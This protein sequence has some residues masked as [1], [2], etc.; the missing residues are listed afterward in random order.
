M[1]VDYHVPVLL[2]ESVEALL[3]RDNGIYVDCTLGGG[4]HSE[5][6]LTSNPT[7]KVFAFD[8]DSEAINHSSQRLTDYAGRITY[9]NDNYANVRTRLAMEFINSIDGI[10]MDLGVSSHQLDDKSR[11]FTFMN[12]ADL[13]MRMDRNSTLTAKDIIN[14]YREE[15]L[16]RIFF[17]FG[18]ERQARKIASIII[19]K[20]KTS[21]IQTTR[22][23]SE[24]IEQAVKGKFVIKSKARIFQA[25]RIEVNNE[26]KSIEKCL[27]D[28]VTIMKSGAR[29]VVLS[30]HS[31][32]DRIVKNF[33]KECE[34]ECICPPHVLKCVCNKKATLKNITRKPIIAGDNEISLNNRAR[35]VKMRI[36][37]KI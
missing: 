35:S 4:G 16:C 30:Y 11:G 15:D 27:N 6:I 13:D 2:N 3:L 29:L 28:A 12:E 31:L 25:L 8:R 5:L 7:V 1:S 26:L 24:I 21:P 14:E 9:I 22:Q 37:E 34:K 33:I 17:E 18:E 32:E 10:I 19:T 20:R 23:L 36:A